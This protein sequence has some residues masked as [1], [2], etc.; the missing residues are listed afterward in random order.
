[1]KKLALSKLNNLFTEISQGRK[2]Y[3]P[4]DNKGQAQFLPYVDGME[5]TKLLNT[6]RSAKDLFFP[7]VENLVSFKV[8]GKEIEIIENRD[9]KEDFVLFGVRACDVKSFE[10]LDRVYLEPD[11]VDTYYAQRRDHAT[12]ISLACNEPEETCFCG[13]FGIDAANPLADVTAWIVGEEM[14]FRCN[15]EK[16]KALMSKI[17]LLVP[18]Q[19]DDVLKT[20]DAIRAIIEKT[21]HNNLTTELF[22]EEHMLEIFNSDKWQSL[23]ESCIGCGTC[24]YICPT[25]QCY[26]IREYDTGKDVKRFRCW[27]SCMFSDFTQM[28]A[29]Q[30]R[31]T[32]KE[33]FRQRFMHKLVYFPAKNQ[34]EY[35][36]VGCGRC[37]Q[38]CPINMNIVKVMKTLKEGS[39]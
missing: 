6:V 39:K 18:A 17:E 34:G 21:P 35:G 11:A 28:S 24:T 20:Q 4:A 26:D 29:G 30:P 22:N 12:V 8:S 9:V 23:S 15:T 38:K 36:C 2:L 32:Q 31:P 1:M 33:R 3:I 19:E 25:C 27:D 37:L 10:T 14:I 16:G 7:Q 13:V 5:M